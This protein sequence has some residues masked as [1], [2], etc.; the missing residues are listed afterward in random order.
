MSIEVKGIY[1]AYGRK[2]VLE[3]TGFT[4]ELGSCVG[5][6]GAN[7]CG[8]STLFSILAGVQGCKSGSFIFEGTDLMKN[9]RLRSSVLG[10]IPQG[11]P[12][13]D[14]LTAYDNLLLWYPKSQLEAESKNGLIKQLGVS[15]FLRVPVRKMSGGMKKRLSIACAVAH[16]PKIIIMDEPT[17]ALDI[18]CKQTISDYITYCKR[19]GKAVILATHEAGELALCDSIYVLRNGVAEPFE[20]SG[21]IAE[22]VELIK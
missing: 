7:G 14:E 20:Y 17:A 11:T 8:K 13:I 12:L 9:N 16:N 15:E 2:R 18:I 21:N 3:G 1:K 10:Y 6:I 5:I 19:S 4:A 22:L